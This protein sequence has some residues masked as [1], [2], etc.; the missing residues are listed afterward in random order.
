MKTT[1]QV[2]YVCAGLG[3]G[4]ALGVLFAP[5]SGDRTRRRLQA[6]ASSGK[7]QVKARAQAVSQAFERRDEIVRAGKERLSEAWE[8]GRSAYRE[9]AAQVPVQPT[10]LVVSLGVLALGAAVLT[11][12]YQ[13]TRGMGGVSSLGRKLETVLD[14]FRTAVRDGSHK[15][16]AIASKTHDLLGAFESAVQRGLRR[17][18]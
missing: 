2:A 3:L 11:A 7:D 8:E 17:Q 18:V 16:S 9:T 5:Q 14:A 12:G 10:S 6:A 13:L 4:G 15:I 1:S